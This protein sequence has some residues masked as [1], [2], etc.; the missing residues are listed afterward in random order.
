MNYPV[1]SILAKKVPLI[2]LILLTGAAICRA[3][4]VYDFDGDGRTDFIVKRAETADSPINWYIFQSRDGFAA[5]AWGYQYAAGAGVSDV[6]AFGDYDGDGRW[7]IT[8]ARS[9]PASPAMIWYVLDSATGSFTARHWGMFNDIPVPQDYDG[10]HKTDLAVYRAGAWH[11]LR[12]S[13]GQ[14]QV[15]SF[16]TGTDEPF[17]GGDYDGDGKDDIAVI[18]DTNTGQ[19]FLYILYSGNGSWAEYNFGVA[20]GNGVASGDYD[21]DGK[22]DVALWNFNGEWYWIRSSDGQLGAGGRFGTFATDSGAPGDYD[23]DGKAD[24]AV[25]RRSSTVTPGT[26]FYFYV[27]QS[28]DGFTALPWGRVP[29]VYVG[30]RRFRKPKGFPFPPG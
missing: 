27:Q 2:I 26:Q 29:D 5:R 3:G 22:A 17:T 19:R 9:G 8:V 21:G 11:I 7:D 14:Y 24:L 30:S 6:D 13:D 10:D 4:A 12:S 28:R 20:E 1:L 18:R 25:F 23:G 16:G 15:V